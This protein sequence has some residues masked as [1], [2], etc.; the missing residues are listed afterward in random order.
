[1]R[2]RERV[3]IFGKLGHI[4][5]KPGHIFRKPGHIFRSHT[6][7]KTGHLLEFL[8]PSYYKSYHKF[9]EN[10]SHFRET[11]SQGHNFRKPGHIF[12]RLVVNLFYNFWSF[13]R[14][15]F[16]LLLT[17][18]VLQHSLELISIVKKNNL[19]IPL[20]LF[21]ISVWTM[22]PASCH[23]GEEGQINGWWLSQVVWMVPRD[24]A[25]IYICLLGLTD[26]PSLPP[27]PS[28]PH[29]RPRLNM[30]QIKL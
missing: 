8:K 10:R 7:T 1:M 19:P 12:R 21:L 30:G 15:K 18:W 6:F 28:P 13:F 25:S 17:W 3:I 16:H 27:P 4:F 26:P 9:E 11:G 20:S 22:R 14:L 5:G 24:L 2:E 29:L 23:P